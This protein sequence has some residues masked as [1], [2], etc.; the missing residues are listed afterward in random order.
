MDTNQT[1]FNGLAISELTNQSHVLNFDGQAVTVHQSVELEGAHCKIIQFTFDL[2]QPTRFR[3]DLQLPE[4]IV[5][6]CV[7]LNGQVL[8]GF[9]SN[10]LPDDCNVPKQATCNGSSEN[11]EK[12]S[13]LVPGQFQSIN[14][15]WISTDILKFY[16]FYK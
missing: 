10:I 1:R 7:T 13:T 15:K 3:L 9:F 5:N 2:E 6:A 11:H 16:L 8:I 12:V 14:F 4:E